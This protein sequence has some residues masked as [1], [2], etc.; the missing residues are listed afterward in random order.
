MSQSQFAGFSWPGTS[1]PEG[2][3]AG[4]AWFSRVGPARSGT[5]CLIVRCIGSP[6]VLKV[7]SQVR[8]FQKVFGP[9]EEIDF[10]IKEH[11]KHCITSAKPFDVSSARR[12]CGHCSAIRSSCS[13]QTCQ[14][15][16]KKMTK[17][18]V[19]VCKCSSESS[20]RDSAR[21]F[22]DRSSVGTIQK[23]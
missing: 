3:E 14:C 16:D 19:T 4:T 5:L 20:S 23:S 8:M 18:T 10:F 13:P 12:C 15:I 17:H 2:P 21:N 1:G 6:R 22:D 11:L 9:H 7:S